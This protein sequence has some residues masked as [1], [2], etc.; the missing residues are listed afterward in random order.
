MKQPQDPFATC[1]HHYHCHGTTQRETPL[2]TC[3][4]L[5]ILRRPDRTRHENERPNQ[6]ILVPN[7]FVVCKCGF[8]F[9]HLLVVVGN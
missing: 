2:T 1:P 5:T 7:R 9:M 3:S 4:N 8:E 6:D